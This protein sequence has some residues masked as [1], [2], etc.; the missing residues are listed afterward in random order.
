MHS[1]ID[2][3]SG[4][5]R[6]H[7]YHSNMVRHLTYLVAGAAFF[8]AT[9]S[10]QIPDQT[11]L[12]KAYNVRYLGGAIGASTD[13]ALSF[14]GT[15]TFDGK[16]GFTVT[17]SGISAGVTLK[18]LTTGTYKVLPSGMVSLTN[19]FAD[20][21]SATGGATI[22]G[23][24]SST[25]IIIGSSTESLY[26]DLFVA[27]PAATSAS[28]ATLTGNY[29]I[30]SMEFLTGSFT[31]S[32]NTFFSATADGKGGFGNMSIAGTAQSLANKATKQTS[33]GVT[34]TLT[35]NGTGQLTLPAPSGVTAAQTLL[36]GQKNLFVSQDGSFFIAGAPTGYDFIIGLKSGNSVTQM[37]GLYWTAFFNNY[38]AGSN[39]DG[40][41]GSSGSANEI[42]S[43]GNLEIEHDRTNNEFFFPYDS[44]YS[45]TFAFDTSGISDYSTTNF[46]S[47]YAVGANADIV[48]GAGASFN[49]LLALYVRAPAMKAP[50]GTTVFLNPQ[51]IVNAANNAPVTTQVAPGEVISLYG[52]G[53]GPA[54]AVT[55]SAP[56]P[57]TLGGTQ[58]LVNGKP[59]PI[60][61]SSAAQVSAVV[62]YDA[63]G[64]G[65]TLSVQVTNGGVQSNVAN[66]YSGATSP[67]MFTIPSGGPFP[68]AI[69]KQDFT[70]MSKSNPAKVGETVS[71]YLTG[72]GPVSPAVTAGSAAPTSPLS[73]LTQQIFIYI[74]GIQ[75]NVVYAGLAPGLGGLY[76]LNVTIPAGVSKGEVGIEIQ[77][78][79]GT[80][81]N[82]AL[83][84]DNFEASMFIQ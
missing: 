14:Q 39:D 3:P 80:G 31:A 50:T 43:A 60:Y 66:V 54:T 32:R 63:P 64:D 62:P 4:R 42:A 9:A 16:G 73:Q 69:V 41:E 21:A 22:F 83:D 10:A 71:M 53:L 68:G 19:P 11:T 51:G 7:W 13:T 52:S 40:I 17:G 44:T 25:G 61:Y 47:F 20:P 78:T 59:A 5:D 29:Q 75:A 15:F 81:Q 35:A 46:P 12:N 38:Q 58:V 37:D 26:C 33:T 67:G 8:A 49:Y 57:N 6:A 34:Y 45:D 24:V 84:S 55:A 23:G 79:T 74:D 72:L 2:T 70:I 30:A 76:Q 65:S 56:F 28:A 77:T 18:Y 82:L 27:L 1:L 48:V 36:A